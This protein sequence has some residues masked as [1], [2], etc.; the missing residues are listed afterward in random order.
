MYIKRRIGNG[1]PP[2]K[3]NHNY[4]EQGF[5]RITQTSNYEISETDLY[6]LSA[7]EK[8]VYRVDYLEKRVRKTEQIIYYLMAGNQNDKNRETSGQE[9][10]SPEKGKEKTNK[11]RLF[12][13]YLLNFCV[14]FSEEKPCPFNFTLIGENCYLF[15]TQEKVN[16]KTANNICRSYGS[17][18][19]EFEQVNEHANM[20]TY[21]HSNKQNFNDKMDVW[22]GGLNPGL[23]WIWSTS[24]KPITN[25]FNISSIQNGTYSNKN[26]ISSAATSKIVQTSSGNVTQTDTKGSNIQIEGTGRCLSM[27]YQQQNGTHKFQ[28]T[29]CAN[30]QGFLCKFVNDHIK[31]EI[32]RI[33]K[34]LMNEI[35]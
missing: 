33:A 29:D 13:F 10:N 24:A 34:S 16:W 25:N 1:V 4:N 20:I 3:E 32:S 5:H 11:K 35:K 9:T 8:L 19:A 22:L 15:G 26:E 23:L 21:L 18:L 30:S 12:L 28:G 27:I 2:V 6:L 31:N 7:I 17:Q 14:F